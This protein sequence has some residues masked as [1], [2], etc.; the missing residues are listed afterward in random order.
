MR[1]ARWRRRREWGGH[2]TTGRAGSGGGVGGGV[3]RRTA[4]AATGGE[5]RRRQPPA[6]AKAPRRGG[7]AR[8]RIV[9]PRAGSRTILSVRARGGPRGGGSTWRRIYDISG[10]A[11]LCL[12]LDNDQT[13]VQK[14]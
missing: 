7:A 10:A 8:G 6:G 1:G 11:D 2:G 13:L 9:P 3:E 4:A 5:R 12:Q 14:N